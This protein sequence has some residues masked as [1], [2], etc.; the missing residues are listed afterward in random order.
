M[1]AKW[2]ADETKLKADIRA[3]REMRGRGEAEGKA[4][5]GKM[6]AKWK[7]K[8]EKANANFERMM[9]KRR[10]AREKWKA[11]RKANSDVLTVSLCKQI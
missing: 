4:Y 3:F 8:Q 6:F 10:T 2:E 7:A 9:A 11:E 1:R 5:M